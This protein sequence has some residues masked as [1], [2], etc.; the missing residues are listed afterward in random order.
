MK[1]E[2]YKFF[3]MAALA[4]SPFATI[5]GGIAP[6][7]DHA[8]TT[9]TQ[10]RLDITEDTKEV[11]L[12]KSDTT[13]F[14]YTNAFVLKHADPYEVRPYIMNASASTMIDGTDTRVEAVKYSDGTGV[15][16]V[17]AEDYRFESQADGTLSIPELIEKLDRPGLSSSS[18]QPKWV[19]YCKHTNPSTIKDVT[20][21]L[22]SSESGSKTFE[23]GKDKVAIDTEINAV[24]FYQIPSNMA[25][26]K[27]LIEEYDAPFDDINVTV[28]IYEFSEEKDLQLGTDYQ[29]W[30]NGVANDMITL[31]TGGTNYFNFNPAYTTQ[32]LDFLVAKGKAKVSTSLKASLTDAVAVGDVSASVPADFM[33]YFNLG[34]KYTYTSMTDNNVTATGKDPDN[35]GATLNRVNQS[36]D[37]TIKATSQIGLELGMEMTAYGEANQFKYNFTNTSIIGFD[38]AGVPRTSTS[39]QKGEMLVGPKSNEIVIGGVEKK[40]VVTVVN[41]LPFLGS[42][43][44]LGYLF[45]SEDNIVKT[46][47]VVT[48]ISYE[49]EDLKKGIEAKDAEVIADV[50]DAEAKLMFDQECPVTGECPVK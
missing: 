16:I 44:V 49:F 34:S 35:N 38:G 50:K 25:K 15:L 19:Y 24:I 20:E 27:A 28:K 36:K 17:S 6:N 10:L 47:Q 8:T 7:G 46:S 32:Y 43:P 5:A 1:K 21:I 41:K 18:G 42:I 11:I 33:G 40:E 22:F 12:S 26:L 14:V 30:V 3:A 2:T 23:S 37:K 45:S 13:P 29:E 31:D 48:V 9:Q 4:V 39:T